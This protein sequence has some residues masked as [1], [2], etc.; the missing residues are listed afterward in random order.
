[1]GLP[2]LANDR[3]IYELTVPST[4]E[5]VKYRPFLVKEQKVMLVAF[6]SKDTK[7]I[8]N[9]ILSSIDSCVEGVDVNSLSTFDVDYMFTKIRAKS[10]GETSKL[11][12]SCTK[13]ESENTVE[14]NL[15]QIELDDKNIRD[16]KI[17]LTDNIL[18][19]MRYPTYVQMM[20]K[21]NLFSEDAAMTDMIFS[22]IEICMKSVQTDDE[23]ILIDD[24][25]KE[26][27]EKFVN[28]LN[29]DQMKKVMDFVENLPALSYESNFKCV[30]CGE[31]NIV[32][33]SGLNDFF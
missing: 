32:K 21:Q 30:K 27:V 23:N 22:N 16:T 20:K 31:H 25:P 14:V 7:Q 33:L 12:M 5:V 10:V 11:V 17:S 29:N 4:K 24:E 9:S 1:M 19:E 3:P 18:V 15:D 2:N 28:N 26:E 6:E 8:L 13:C